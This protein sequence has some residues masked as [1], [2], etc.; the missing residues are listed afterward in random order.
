VTCRKSR[1]YHSDAVAER[2]AGAVTRVVGGVWM[3]GDAGAATDDA[4]DE[5][6]DDAT[7]DPPQL[8]VVRF[9][10]DHCTISADAS[11][12]LLHRRGYR[13]ATAKAPMRETLAAAL[14]VASRWDPAHPL[15]DPF[16]GSGT[17]PIEAAMIARRI[18]PGLD[19][20]FAAE[21][22]PSVPTGRWASARDHAGAGILPK[23]PAPILGSDR[24]TGAVEAARAN[25]ERAGVAGDVEFRRVPLAGAAPEGAKCPPGR[26]WLVSNPPYGIRVGEAD[27]LRPLYAALGDL[28]RTSLQDW[29]VTLVTADEVMPRWTGL[30]F[31]RVLTTRNGGIPV[32]FVSRA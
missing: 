7:E 26:G 18:P 5:A 8:F 15:L 28:V 1:L 23:A 21:G 22:W 19:R 12:A 29:N 16:C 32:E 14:L 31:R 17:I 25:A 30:P 2:V 3:G 4:T 27:A 6:I 24:D 11:G 9:D 13:L 10:R 20:R